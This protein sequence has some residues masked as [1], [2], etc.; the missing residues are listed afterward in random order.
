MELIGRT[1]PPWRLLSV[2]LIGM[3]AFTAH[4]SNSNAAVMT[5][6]SPL[7]VPATLNTTSN[8]NYYGMYTPVPPNPEAPNGL[9]HTNHWG[10]DTAIW[11]VALANSSASAPATGQVVKVSVEGCAP[12]A[13]GGPRPLTQ[14]HLQDISPVGGGSV[15]VNLTSQAFDIPICGERGASGSTVSTYQPINLCVSAGDYVAFNDEGGYV[16]NI[17]RSGVPYQVLG[18][19]RG[20]VMNSFIRGNATNN[21]ATLSASDK[22]AMDGFAESRD[23]ELMLQ[24]TLATGP[25]ATHICSGGTGGLPPPPPAVTLHP[26]TDGVNHQR[27]VAVA[28]YCS[29][30]PECSGAATLSVGTRRYGQASFN[31]PGGH[32]SHVP[33]R[34]SPQLMTLVRR[35]HG[36]SAVLTVAVG[37]KTFTQTVTVKIY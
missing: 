16:P 13:A 15:H 30:T 4:A 34:V 9:F 11:N 2:L 31:L 23:Q 6:G 36:V 17:Y 8:L 20:S 3:L 32:T 35:S 26:Q 19:T 25:D 29:V 12:P 14:F 5:F 10:A 33:I 1:R 28:M 7:S 37:G 24:A 22:T 21:G 18:A 27:I